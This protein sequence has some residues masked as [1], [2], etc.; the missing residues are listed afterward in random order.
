MDWL[1]GKNR[2]KKCGSEN[3]CG[4]CIYCINRKNIENEILCKKSI[5]LIENFLN[6]CDEKRK[7]YLIALL[8]LKNNNIPIEIMEEFSS[9]YNI[10]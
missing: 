5:E 10:N 3:D 7:N 8:L 6:K 4:Y 1:F 2:C 9:L